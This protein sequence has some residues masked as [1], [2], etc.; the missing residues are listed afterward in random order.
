MGFNS[1]FKGLSVNDIVSLTP[2]AASNDPISLQNSV[3]CDF[4]SRS[5]QIE[6]QKCT[7]PLFIRS[8]YVT[9]PFL[10]AMHNYTHD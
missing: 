3:I 5:E 4:H 1:V 7:L 9:I 2:D 10:P 8:S 6:W